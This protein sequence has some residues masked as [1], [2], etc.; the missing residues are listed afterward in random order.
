MN[1]VEAKILDVDTEA[2]AKKLEELG[3]EKT[4][5]TV[6]TDHV[7][8]KDGFKGFFRIREQ[9]DVVVTT[10]KTR[11]GAST[12]KVKVRDE[13]EHEV[14]SKEAGEQEAKALGFA[15]ERSVNK[16]RVEYKIGQTHF[17]FDTYENI[18]TF[19]EIESPTIDEV[20]S[21]AEK[22]GFAK[23]DL[24]NWGWRQLYRHY[25]IQPRSS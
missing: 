2:L 18:P 5:D 22:L 13:R 23:N 11:I 6:L 25:G 21:W 3:A 16:R 14:K 24:K 17:A 7:F 19:L 12:K 20:L 15:H 1:E 10:L 8:Y 9:E 4:C